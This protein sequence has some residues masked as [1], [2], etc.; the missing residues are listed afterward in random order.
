MR[1]IVTMWWG[2]GIAFAVVA[3]GT[4]WYLLHLEK[5]NDMA[6]AEKSCVARAEAMGVESAWGMYRGCMITFKGVTIPLRQVRAIDIKP[7]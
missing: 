1:W 4:L 5:S 2:I 6:W 7:E 3:L